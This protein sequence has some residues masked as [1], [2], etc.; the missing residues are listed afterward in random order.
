MLNQPQRTTLC[1]GGEGREDYHLTL[2]SAP[3]LTLANDMQQPASIQ[4]LRI[5]TNK[6]TPGTLA[7]THSLLLTTAN[8]IITHRMSFSSDLHF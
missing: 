7:T 3:L 2:V 1:S 5:E 8:L 6:K 4:R